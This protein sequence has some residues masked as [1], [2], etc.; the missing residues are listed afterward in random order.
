MPAGTLLD[1]TSLRARADLPGIARLALMGD[2]KHQN[3]IPRVVIPVKSD[4]S[5]FA[6]R[7]HELAQIR[8][9]GVAHQGMPFEDSDRLKNQIDRLRRRVG[10]AF[11]EKVAKFFRIG[12]RPLRVADGRH[13]PTLP[14]Y[15]FRAL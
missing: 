10:I 6:S 2:S 7:D 14:S 12:E 13:R 15:R 9:R 3:A 4:I 1:G 5:G 11:G 8:F